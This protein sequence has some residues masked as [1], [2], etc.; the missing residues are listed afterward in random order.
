MDSQILKEAVTYIFST[1]P[2]RPFLCLPMSATLYAIL[3]DNHGY[4]AKLVTGNLRLHDQYI[5]KQ[6]FSITEAKD[7][8]FQQWGGHAWVEIEGLICD[9]SFF[10]TLY[11]DAFNKP[12]KNKLIEIFGEGQG[13]LIA[14]AADMPVLT[15]ERVEYLSDDLATGIIKGFETLLKA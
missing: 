3:K 10:R 9:L 4:E 14:S 6:D 13:A 2:Y 1:I 15:Y 12:Y 11:S 7:G 8:E 5:F